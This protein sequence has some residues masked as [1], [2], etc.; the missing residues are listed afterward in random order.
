MWDLVLADVLAL[1]GVLGSSQVFNAVAGRNA[2]VVEA[3]IGLERLGERFKY[4]LGNRS[5]GGF[6]LIES[7]C[8]GRALSTHSCWVI[9]H[10]L[11]QMN[12]ESGDIN[13]LSCLRTDAAP[14]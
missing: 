12:G 4:R 3:V 14:S 6:G 13:G 10:G 7:G 5:G 11:C 8:C 9:F 1:A 2:T